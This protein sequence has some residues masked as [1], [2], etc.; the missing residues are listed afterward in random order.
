MRT[1]T[2]RMGYPEGPATDA[3][4][5]PADPS[6]RTRRIA[7]AVVLAVVLASMGYV[8][9]VR[10]WWTA[11]HPSVVDGTAERVPAN[12]PTGYFDPEGSDDPDDRVAFRLDD[13]V[14]K[15]GDDADSGS[16][17]PC[18]R[19]AGKRVSVQ[20]GLIEVTRPY[21]SGSYQQVLSVTC[22]E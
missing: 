10:S 8:V 1:D 19:D 11:H 5:T 3:A 4:Q 18:L 6:L 13:V 15:A 22:P 7:L 16:I 12:V 21:G 9:A 20:V 14:W 2:S 17:P